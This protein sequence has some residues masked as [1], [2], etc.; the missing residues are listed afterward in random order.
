[1]TSTPDMGDHRIRVGIVGLGLAGRNAARE[2]VKSPLMQLA[3]VCDLNADVAG[4]VAAPSGARAYTDHEEMYA[5]P[6]IEAILVATPTH[7]RLPHIVEALKHGKHVMSEKPLARSSDEA[8]NIVDQVSSSKLVLTSINTRGRDP[9][10]QAMARI[11]RSSDFGPVLSLT[12][13][14]YKPWVLSPRYDYELDPD[15]GG[16][17][18]FRQ[19][20]HQVEIARTIIDDQVSSVSATVGHVDTPVDSYGNFNALLRFRSGASASLVFNGYGYFDTSELTWG[21]GEGGREHRPGEGIDLRRNESWKQVKY[22]TPP[23]GPGPGARA[24]GPRNLSVYGLTIVS[25]QLADLRPGRSGI[26][27]YDYDSIH[28]VPVK[29]SDGGIQQDFAE[30]YATVREG[31]PCLHDAAWGSATVDICEAI[32][33]SAQ[34]DAVIRL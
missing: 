5:D 14:M 7:L 26:L 33:R 22:A 17:V 32:W 1:M 6:S 28:E 13:V 34:E 16:G 9:I 12:N 25:C 18:N 31:Q 2:V 21:I 11:I 27:V 29:E 15:L 19:A 30:F 4:Q 8:R 10:V 23:S 3:A 20:P 24:A